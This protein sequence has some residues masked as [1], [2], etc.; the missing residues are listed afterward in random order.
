MGMWGFGA[1]GGGGGGCVKRP[2]TSPI[3]GFVKMAG[4]VFG[5]SEIEKLALRLI[6]LYICRLVGMT[7]KIE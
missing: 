5:I 6:S 7:T 3:F 1:E 2:G 4:Q